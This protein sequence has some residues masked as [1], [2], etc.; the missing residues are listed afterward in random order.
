MTTI[1]N[2]LSIQDNRSLRYSNRV[3]LTDL[4]DEM[5]KSHPD[6]PAIIFNGTSITYSVLAQRAN[7][8]ANFLTANLGIVAEMPVGVMMDRSENLIIALLGII[9]SGA[10]YIPMPPV[11][12][13]GRIKN[14]I[15]QSAPVAVITEAN[16]QG[17]LSPDDHAAYQRIFFED[18]PWDDLAADQPPAVIR[19][20]DLMYIM[21]TSGSTGIP[22]GVAIEHGAV[23]NTFIYFCKEMQVTAHDRF[24]ALTTYAFDISVLELFLPLTVGATIV[25]ASQSDQLNHERLAAMFSESEITIAQ[26]T[27]VTCQMLV[28]NEHWQPIAGTKIICGGEYLNEPLGMSLI[29]RDIQLWNGYGPTETTIWTTFKKVEEQHDLKSIGTPIDNLYISIVDERCKTVAPGEIGEIAI[30]GTGL[31]RGYYDQP[32]KTME[33]FVFSK[34][35]SNTRMY[36]SGDLGRILPDGE[37]Q[38]LGRKD[39]QVKIRGFRIELGEIEKVLL[40]V[41]GVSNAVVVTLTE[42]EEY[43]KKLAAYIV[44]EDGEEKSA[45]EMRE[46]ISALKLTAKAKLPPYMLPYGYMFLPQMPLN[47][48]GK[49]SR[50]DLPAWDDTAIT[51]TSEDEA[52]GNDI[53]LTIKNIWM[54]LI[55]L[56]GMRMSD[57]FFDLGGHSILLTV[58]HKRLLRKYGDILNMEDMF[59]YTTIRG[60]ADIIQSKLSNDTGNRN[61]IEAILASMLDD[62]AM[63]PEVRFSDDLPRGDVSNPRHIFLTGATGFLGIHLLIEL[64]MRTNAEI[65]CL[66]RA[67]NEQIGWQRLEQAFKYFLIDEQYLDKKRINLVTGDLSLPKF[68]IKETIYNFLSK[69]VDIIYHS[70][71]IVSYIQPYSHIRKANILG[72]HEIIQ[73]ATLNRLK[74]ISYISSTAVFSWGQYFTRKAWMKEDDD[75]MQNLDA[76]A[77]GSNYVK[78]KWVTERILEKVSEIGI[79]I[80][81]F[82][83]GFILSHSTTG[84]TAHDQW[85]A[86]LVKAC[87]NINC[88]PL[89]VGSK[90]ALVSVDYVAKAMVHISSNPKAIGKKF[91][92]TPD[93]EKDITTIEFLQRLNEHFGFNMQATTFLDWRDKWEQDEESPLYP[94]LLLYKGNTYEGQALMELYQ[95]SYYFDC[96]NTRK[97]LVNSG[98]KCE[99]I[100]KDLLEPYLRNIQVIS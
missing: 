53:E 39:T 79:P 93:P 68:G 1:V 78:S 12:P 95:N 100:D 9:K 66:V 46:I 56:P 8:L 92:L 82:R 61:E 63:I 27:P 45:E 97:F 85:Y 54:D 20:E 41:N 67:E 31:A 59:K 70:G 16:F 13:A 21:F 65:H 74:C 43:E 81:I 35:G 44:W 89:L 4:F 42:G 47:D 28:N 96:S 32:E 19:P 30:S 69:E 5:V 83:S 25:L 10:A 48:N 6:K 2:N 88:Y 18:I 15:G 84:A 60:L 94:L 77:R 17:Q 34:D 49:V 26:A 64:L 29:N 55:K 86:R 22:K 73:L 38:F 36:L 50:K 80:V 58:V 33:K 51:V 98:I 52:A 40:S 57:D 62:A 24:L 14:I 87:V 90:D 71:N 72:L 37:I 76:V 99:D 7:K 75:L 3:V 91:H 23:M 11:Y